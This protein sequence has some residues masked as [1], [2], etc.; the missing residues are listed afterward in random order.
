LKSQHRSVE[1]LIVVPDGSDDGR[2]EA[3]KGA[4]LTRDWI[5]QDSLQAA[6]D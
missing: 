3:N 1:D 6:A 5:L 2:L 4:V